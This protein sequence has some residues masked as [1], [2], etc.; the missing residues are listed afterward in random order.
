MPSTIFSKPLNK[1]V[2]QNTA[3]IAA[4]SASMGDANG[5]IAI[6]AT[7]NTAPKAIPAGQFV[8]WSGGLYTANSAIASGETLSSSNLTAVPD[9]G[10]NALN[11]KIA[12]NETITNLN[13]ANLEGGHYYYG[14]TATG[15]PYT[16]A[17]RLIQIKSSE[18]AWGG[19]IAVPNSSSFLMY[20]RMK[21]SSG[22]GN[23]EELA[24]NGKIVPIVENNI[25]MDVEG[26]Y[27]YVTS[28]GREATVLVPLN[29]SNTA[30]SMSVTYLSAGLRLASGGYLGGSDGFD[31]SQYIYRT[32]IVK[33][34]SLVMIILNKTDGWGVTNN[35]PF[36]GRGFLRGSLS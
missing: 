1:L 36:T 33:K 29:L 23:W 24:V 35:T 10:L 32:F 21:T 7:G 9:G 4:L 13:D 20:A 16:T 28:G 12:F 25:N 8:L 31:F 34:Q 2:A 18:S 26:L 5:A 3:D 6:V 11:S 15:N 27:G 14:S 22:Y 19:Q 17:G 30:S